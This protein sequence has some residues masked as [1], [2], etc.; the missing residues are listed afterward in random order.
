MKHSQRAKHGVS[1]IRLV[2]HVERAN[3]PMILYRIAKNLLRRG[4]GKDLVQPSP[5]HT[6][7]AGRGKPLMVRSH[8]GG[9]G[10]IL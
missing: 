2:K 9:M 5:P 10:N 6:M 7:G 3:F 8:S 4:H 1:T